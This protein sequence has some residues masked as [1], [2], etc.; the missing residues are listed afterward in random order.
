MANLSTHFVEQFST[1]LRSILK[2]HS[3]FQ[4]TRVLDIYSVIDAIIYDLEIIDNE[5]TSPS[6]KSLIYSKN[7]CVTGEM[8]YT[9]ALKK[10]FVALYVV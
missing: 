8:G 4:R 10:V 9:T 2:E 5:R 3:P 1:N 6:K 7:T